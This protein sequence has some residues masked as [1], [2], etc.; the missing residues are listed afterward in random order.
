MTLSRSSR[1]RNH[2]NI[3]PEGI[4]PSNIWGRVQ[5]GTSYTTQRILRSHGTW[6]PYYFDSW[7]NFEFTISQALI[8]CK[9][10]LRCHVNKLPR[11]RWLK[12]Y[13]KIT[14]ICGLFRVNQT[15][16]FALQLQTNRWYLGSRLLIT[17]EK[18]RNRKKHN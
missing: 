10:L 12:I 5:L 17:M 2:P 1:D 3:T 18:D 16:N 8:P 4:P 15:C 6:K 13:L 9:Q 11:S 14:G 7:N